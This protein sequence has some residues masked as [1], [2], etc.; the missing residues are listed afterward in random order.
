MPKAKITVVGSSNIDYAMRMTRLPRPGET[1]TDAEFLQ[2]FGGK[3]ANQAIAAARAGGDTW[4]VSCVGDENL[5]DRMIA[6]FMNDGIHTD[7][8]FREK[9]CPSGTALIMT[10]EG[11]ENYLAVA[12]GANYRLSPLQIEQAAGALE[13]SS[14][15]VVQ[16]EIAPETLL[17]AMKTA[18]SLAIPVMLNYAPVRTRMPEL[19]GLATVLVVNESEALNLTGIEITCTHDASKAAELL[20]GMGARTVV[21]TLGSAGA[22]ASSHQLRGHIPSFA[23]DVVDTTAAGDTFC[24]ALAVGLAEE[25]S[26]DVAL[27]FASAAAALTVTRMGAQPS[28][29]LRTDIDSLLQ[30]VC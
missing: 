12:P 24:G 2:T 11:G 17:F 19:L 7:Y 3:G 18:R 21:I 29:P 14:M 15:I 25:R 16:C 9:G 8:V 27:R 20:R 30:R 26:L 10:G 28:I 4:F 23:V 22:W 5:A 1:I 6:G 13:D